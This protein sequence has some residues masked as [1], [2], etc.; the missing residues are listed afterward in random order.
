MA[1]NRFRIWT[2]GIWLLL[3]QGILLAPPVAQ[4]Q[5]NFNAWLMT[6]THMVGS[7]G[8][9]DM[10]TLAVDQARGNVGGAPSI[11]FDAIFDVGDWIGDQEVPIHA[12][13]VE[14]A[15]LLDGILG[16]SRGVFFSAAGNH[17]GDPKEWD[18]GTFAQWYV[19]PL[20]EAAY[21]NTSKFSASEYPSAIDFR[22]LLSYSG[23]RWDR[24]LVRSG[25]VIWIMLSD[26]NEF[27]TLAEARGDTSGLYQA[28]RG[29]ASG[30]PDGGYPS[31]SVTLDTFEWWKG[32]V[33]DPDFATNILVTCHHLLPRNTTITTDDGDPGEF[34]GPSGSVGPNGEIGGQLYWIREYD[35][36]TN[37][38]MQYCQT[39]PF[40]DYLRDH[41]GAIDIWSGGHS[42]IETP[43]QSING[44]GI[45]VRKYGVTFLS[46]GA[47]TRTHSGG[48]NQ[49]S[50]LLTF[51]EGNTNAIMNVYV[52]YHNYGTLY[53][54]GWYTN[55][56][57]LV[58]LSQ[59][60]I[61]PATTSNA[62]SPVAAA[63]L[64]VVPDAPADPAGPRYYWDLDEDRTYDF[65]NNNVAVGADGSPYGLYQD[66]SVT[67][68]VADSYN[69][70]GQSL[71][72]S[73]TTGRVEFTGPY[74]PK[75][76][77]SA[78]TLDCRLKTLST[79][80]QE[81][82]SYSAATGV[83]KFRLYYSGSA[84]I[85]EAGHGGSWHSAQWS[86]SEANDGAW[87]QFV[88]VVDSANDQIRLYV[89]GELRGEAAW[90]GDA[91]IDANTD[92][93]VI[94]ATGGENTWTRPFGGLI[95][96]LT[97]YDSVEE[98]KLD[99]PKPQ[100][101]PPDSPRYWW[102]LDDGPGSTTAV[103]STTNGLDGTLEFMN[104]TLAWT[105]D[106]PSATNYALVLDGV[107]NR[108]NMG[109]VTIDWPG[110]TISAWIKSPAKTLGEAW[111]VVAKDRVGVNGNFILWHNTEDLWQF[112]V[113]DSIHGDWRRATYDSTAEFN[114]SW[115]HI[116]GVLN[117]DT[118]QV[119][120]YV[121][122]E[123]K[124]PASWSGG[125]LDDNDNEVLVI[126]ADSTPGTPLHLF[127]GLIDDVRIYDT[128][129]STSNIVFLYE[130]PPF[131]LDG[132]TDGD[133]L[134]DYW[135]THYG[136]DPHLATGDDGANGDP[137][138]DLF[139]NW[140]ERIAGTDPQ[141]AGSLLKIES[142]GYDALG[143]NLVVQWQSVLLKTYDLQA[144][145][146]L[147]DGFTPLQG[148]TNLPANPPSN[149]AT[150]NVQNA[151]TFFLRSRVVSPQ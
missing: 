91:L 100:P 42:H 98:P 128:A 85:F 136:I 86:S 88:G 77:W 23:T 73:S 94:G 20:G 35:E 147:T 99:P 2:G 122:G 40:L 131:S 123:Q 126:G 104:A 89:D 78:L 92:R 124:T 37:E 68:Y 15:G 36:N 112:Q 34:H 132:D 5:T 145:T 63:G 93:L 1:R 120:L 82:V 117:P 108:V 111:R 30:M 44:R 19:N 146:N 10:V 58:P 41:P 106:T 71:D 8:D 143:S 54:V 17:D 133:G 56:A 96:E 13:G 141:H 47:I 39:R 27:D 113:Y 142:L 87:H 107:S 59:P 38:V 33:E 22:P 129:L 101:D 81:A 61:C 11:A 31:G 14:L 57:R 150:V 109:T 46:V 75:M 134:E 74:M 130:N 21:T 140:Q 48:E 12:E 137:D 26:R 144:T 84:W 151:R 65:N 49:M 4:A 115:H 83:G 148:Y 103:D 43:V 127:N 60:F 28:G 45:A 6:C 79:A 67:N 76:E 70:L 139:L 24:Y 9:E 7:S 95:D 29:S 114:N 51:E 118:D 16:D 69:G 138:S 110:I 125:T 64:S 135:E 80:P 97:F 50:R 90:P 149:V 3:V 52:H 18:V 53:P 105:N 119:L 25:N 121:D 116:A 72:F 102:K 62:P 32:V 55:A 66:M